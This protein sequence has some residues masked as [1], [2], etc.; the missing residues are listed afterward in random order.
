MMKGRHCLV[1]K[2]MSTTV[3]DAEFLVRL[4]KERKLSLAVG[5]MMTRNAFNM[6]A[7]SLVESADIGKVND[8]CLHM[9]FCYGASP[10]EASTWRCSDPAELGDR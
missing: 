2:P 3:K 4:A 1:E 10:E 9:E 5:H 6:K 7:R 8:I